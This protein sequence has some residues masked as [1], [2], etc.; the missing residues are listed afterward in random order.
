MPDLVNPPFIFGPYVGPLAPT[1]PSQLGTNGLFYPLMTG[2][3]GRA[4]PEQ[5]PPH[6]VDVRDVALAHIRA[7]ELSPLSAGANVRDKRFVVAQP[8]TLTWK[9]AVEYF[10]KNRPD[11]EGRLPSTEGAPP[12]PGPIAASDTTRAK[13]VLGITEYI[14]WEKTVNDAIDALLEVEKAWAV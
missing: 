11:L 7:L 1:N 10:S 8:K 12:L 13:E 3:A 4:L 14:S 9:E 2:E 6:F 5:T